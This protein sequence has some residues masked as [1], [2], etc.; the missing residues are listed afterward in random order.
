[1]TRPNDKHE[2]RRGS[3]LALTLWRPW[4]WAIMHAR[5]RCENRDWRI[6]ARA[7][8]DWVAIHAGQKLDKATVQAFRLGY[9][10]EVAKLVPDE[11]PTGIVCAVRFSQPNRFNG[12]PGER[13]FVDDDAHHWWIDEVVTLAEPLPIMGAQGLWNVN[14]YAERVIRARIAEVSRAA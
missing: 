5:K 2:S 7:I 1:M 3:M 14:E 13:L 6:P 4:P 9:Y 8:K 11:H 10:G 12:D